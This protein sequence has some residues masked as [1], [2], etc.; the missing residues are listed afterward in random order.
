[1]TN[2]TRK[3]TNGCIRASV[4]A[5]ALTADDLLVKIRD[6]LPECHSPYEYICKN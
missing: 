1:M 3:K 5:L 2:Q 6:L 4:R